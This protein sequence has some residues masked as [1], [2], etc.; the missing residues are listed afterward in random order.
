MYVDYK[1]QIIDKLKLLEEYFLSNPELRHTHDLIQ[2]SLKELEGLHDNLPSNEFTI[3]LNKITENI[4]NIKETYSNFM[5]E[6]IAELS[7]APQRQPAPKPDFSQILAI[8]SDMT[9]KLTQSIKDKV[10]QITEILNKIESGSTEI[11]N[12]RYAVNQNKSNS[13]L[14]MS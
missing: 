7:V 4:K 12:Q 1:P 3:M 5:N 8:V 11:E 2:E 6:K 9:R 13:N 10:D 14:E